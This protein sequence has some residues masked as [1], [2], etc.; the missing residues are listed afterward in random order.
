MELLKQ[1]LP[2]L[3]T[4]SLSLI[5]VAAGLASARGD[6]LY[7]LT[8]GRLLW[9][10]IL[11]ICILPLAFAMALVAIFTLD[12]SV[13]AGILLMAL[14][15]V[16][17]LVMGKALKAGGAQQYVYGIQ[18]AA[19]FMA[20]VSVPL[21]GSL[22]ARFY[23]VQAQFPV[24]VVARNIAI[25][26][27]LPLCIGLVLGR[28][29]MPVRASRIA[30]VVSSIGNVLLLTAFVP[31][32]VVA[33]PEIAKLIGNGAILVIALFV[34]LSTL[35]GHLLGDPASPS[36]LAFAAA[37][38]HPGIALALVSA[39]EGDRSISAAVL[40]VLLTGMMVLI[41]YQIYITRKDAG[42]AGRGR[43]HVV[44]HG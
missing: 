38:R 20:L 5:M 3:L 19:A 27:F 7:V 2:L 35:G 13:R 33:W 30:P 9:R 17:P 11:A 28:W 15:P 29:V 4:V 10:A 39:N 42:V 14:S 25:G 43:S 24:A 1:I 6:F 21:L 26:V 16:P 37:M 41:P 32:V 36:S 31:I 8:R 44:G 34:V 23:D 40:L 12:L 18:A 22:A